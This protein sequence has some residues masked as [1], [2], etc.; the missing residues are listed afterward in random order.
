[1]AQTRY[2]TSG[3]KIR[4]QVSSVKGHDYIR[5]IVDFGIVGDKRKRETFKT[6]ARAKTAIRKWKSAQK[7]DAEKRDILATRI[8]EKAEKLSTDNLLDA[9]RALESLK[10]SVSLEAAARFYISH[11]TPAGGAKTV[12]ELYDGYLLSRQ[13]AN[14]RPDTLRDIR[15]YL[16]PFTDPFAATP[17]QHVTTTDLE[18]WMRKQ[19]GSPRT[20]NKRRIHLVGLFNY[21]VDRKYCTE[22]PAS[23]LVRANVPKS[24]PYIMPPEDVATLMQYAHQHETEIIPYLALCLFAGLRPAGEMSRIDWKDINLGRKEIFISD[25]TSKTGDERYIDIQ[26]NLAK[27]LAPHDQASGPILFSRRK[28]NRIRRNITIQWEPNCMRH[29]FGSYHL[30]MYDNAGK[31]AL[32]M[33]HRDIGTLFEYYRRAV[34]KKDADKYWGV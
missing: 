1:M 7:R 2:K 19:N 11:N 27:W 12:Q 30:A 32:Q 15:G 25:T 20:R 22:N 10:G 3:P 29:S 31:T 13:L 18:H 5:W 21:A 28:F 4:K 14:R 17:V 34:R 33:G 24:K 16:K 9:S 26:D 8:G 23:A 6:E